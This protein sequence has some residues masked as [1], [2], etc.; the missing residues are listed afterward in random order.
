MVDPTRQHVAYWVLAASVILGV[1][2][3][4]FG[5]RSLATRRRY[6]WQS[7]LAIS[8]V[9][10]LCTRSIGSSLGTLVVGVCGGALLLVCDGRQRMG[11]WVRAGLGLAMVCVVLLSAV[12]EFSTIRDFGHETPEAV[13]VYDF[14]MNYL[15]GPGDELAAGERLFSE[16]MPRL[17]VVVAVLLAAWQRTFGFVSMGALFHLNSQ[18]NILFALLTFGL[19]VRICRGV[20]VS[21]LLGLVVAFSWLHPYHGSVLCPNQSAV[22]HLNFVWGL[23]AIFILLRLPLRKAT[24]WLGPL[25]VALLAYNIETGVSVTAGAIAAVLVRH[26][27][28]LISSPGERI[29]AARRFALASLAMALALFAIAGL[30]LPAWPRIPAPS[31]LLKTI[32]TFASGY[33]GGWEPLGP[34]TLLL[35][36]HAAWV[37]FEAAA[38]PQSCGRRGAFRVAVATSILAWLPY[39]VN[40][41]DEWNLWVLGVLYGYLLVDL[42]RLARL[43]FDRRPR[44]RGVLS[45]AVIA[46]VI[47]PHFWAVNVDSLK[48]FYDAEV[49]THRSNKPVVSGVRL[50]LS[51]ALELQERAAMLRQETGRPLYVT[52]FPFLMTRLSGRRSAL[53]VGDALFSIFTR[54]EY[55]GLLQALQESERILL[56]SPLSKAGTMSTHSSYMG[57]LRRDLS[58]MGFSMVREDRSWEIWER[59]GS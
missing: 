52:G 33:G 48:G 45:A 15:Y 37:L 36:G 39:Y 5:R 29:A 47:L 2:W 35:I 58:S 23:W 27:G 20:R 41:A 19:L 10:F 31:E 53:P 51:L 32:S 6:P 16:V 17:S 57:G 26:R 21:A 44:S 4:L 3:S 59:E 56:D 49:S 43:S 42:F 24:L 28:T 9:A 40:R 34:F 22:R 18:I 14:H 50:R 7:V 54:A 11:R 55:A 13:A 1:V 25:C 8:A 46:L 30:V 12:R 38:R